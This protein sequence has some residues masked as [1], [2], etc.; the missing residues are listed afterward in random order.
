MPEA[1]GLPIDEACGRF[2]DRTYLSGRH[3][4]GM[5]IYLILDDQR[6]VVVLRVVRAG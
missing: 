3:N 4:Q 6:R 1:I 2:G 5:A